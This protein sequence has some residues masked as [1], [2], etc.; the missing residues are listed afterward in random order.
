MSESIMR[1]ATLLSADFSDADLTEADFDQANVS[2]ADFKGTNLKDA[3]N[4]G[5]AR[6][7]DNAVNLEYSRF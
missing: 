5:A 4:V 7:L 6:G 1:R 3:L 2:G